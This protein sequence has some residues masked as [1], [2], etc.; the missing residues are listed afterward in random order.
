M[1]TVVILLAVIGGGLAVTGAAV[2]SGDRQTLVPA[3]EAV[4]EGFAR[5]ISE[6]R[7]ALARRHLSRG[8]RQ[9]E[10]AERLRAS[11]E[12]VLLR[13]G[14]PNGVSAEGEW[15]ADDRAAARALIEAERGTAVLRLRM[16]REAGL[17][18]I[19]ELPGEIRAG[20]RESPAR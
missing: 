13:L 3:P 16:K 15:M 18:K 1:K 9:S 12:P 5:Q 6:A 10:N 14:E 2:S 4:A 11:F 20:I 7:Y 8:L 17:W 19:D